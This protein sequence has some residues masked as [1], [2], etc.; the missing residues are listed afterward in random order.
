MK[1]FLN[2]I[3]FA[4]LTFLYKEQNRQKLNK[5]N[6]AL[7]YQEGIG[8]AR[9]TQALHDAA[10]WWPTAGKRHRPCWMEGITK[11]GEEA[12]SASELILLWR[13]L[14]P[15]PSFIFPLADASVAVRI[16]IDKPPEPSVVRLPGSAH[17]VLV[18]V[19]VCVRF[20]YT[21]SQAGLMC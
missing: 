12:S 3:V 10:L 16:A 6:D 9:R 7:D 8:T 4:V 20:C 21:H 17:N 1:L 11:L 19:C 14:D 5:K 13:L 18:G 2:N 15:V